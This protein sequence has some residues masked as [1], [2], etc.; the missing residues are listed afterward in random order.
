MVY[1]ALKLTA[2]LICGATLTGCAHSAA[3]TGAAGAGGAAGAAGAGGAADAN[4]DPADPY[5]TTN[6]KLFAVNAVLD[7]NVLHPVATA[8]VHTVPQ[9]G[10]THLHN[11]LSNIGNPTQLANDV[12][13]GKPRK[14]GNTFMRLLINTTIGLGGVFDVATSWHF[15]DH[16]TDFGLTLA[17]WGV[18]SGPYLYLPIL[19]PSNPRDGIG[20]GANS[21]LDPFTWVSF[22]GSATFGVTRFAVGAVDGRARYLSATNTI[23]KT[24]LDPYATYRSLYQ[25]NRAAAVVA[26]R[27]DLPRTLPDWYDTDRP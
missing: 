22:G 13:Q 25:Q 2:I 3:G 14:A 6:R 21:V 5:E 20:Y 18:P 9:A 1:D 10:R 7:R 23:A 8:Y 27:K 4:T 11:V 15:P 17:V 26:A 19:G 16:D 12:L 24:A